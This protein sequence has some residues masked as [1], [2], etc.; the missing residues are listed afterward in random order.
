MRIDLRDFT[1]YDRS[2]AAEAPED[3][4]DTHIIDLITGELIDNKSRDDLIEAW[5]RLAGKFDELYDYRRELIASLNQFVEPKGKRTQYV[6]GKT[7]K[8]KVT[9]PDRKFDQSQLKEAFNSYPKYRDE[10][11][12]IDRLAVKL[13]EFKKAIKTSGEKDW[14]MFRDMVKEAEQ[15]PTANPKFEPIPL[16][17][18]GLT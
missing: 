6:R 11:L 18:G 16:K 7:R 15:P 3:P 8:M 4:R 14:S 1:S 2:A 9:L 17:K 12:R 5:E 13:T 10:M